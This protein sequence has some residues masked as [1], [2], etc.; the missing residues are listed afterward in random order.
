MNDKESTNQTWRL[1]EEKIEELQKLAQEAW[2]KSE[3]EMAVL[4]ESTIRAV[5]QSKA[6]VERL[7]NKIGY[8]DAPP[9]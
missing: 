4:G 2:Q 8:G 9:A 7:K 5:K 1:V 3:W 6:A